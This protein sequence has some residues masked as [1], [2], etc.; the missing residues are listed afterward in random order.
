M[1]I[2]KEEYSKQQ[3]PYLNWFGLKC[4]LIIDHPD[5]IQMVMTS[6]SCIEK[7]NIYPNLFVENIGQHIGRGS[8]DIFH[9]S[10]ACAM[11]II[12][13]FESPKIFI[14]RLIKLRHEGLIT[15]EDVRDQV[16]FIMFAGQDTSS[17]TIAMTI[18]L[19]AMHP[20]IG[21]RVVDEI[22]EVLDYLPVDS[23][24]TME[25]VNKLTYLE[26][27]IKET[28]RLHPVVPILFRHCT[29]Y[30]SMTNFVIS[31]DTEVVIPAIR[32]HRRKDIWGEDAD[33]FN[34][35]HFPKEVSSKRSPFAFVAFSNG[36]RNCFGR[37][38]AFISIKTTLA[39]VLRS[40]KFSTHLG[41]DDLKFRLEITSKPVKKVLR[42]KLWNAYSHE[43]FS[44]SL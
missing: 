38:F 41:M 6:K 1:D 25:H 24:L 14:D 40:S 10:S 43:S 7:S 21:K 4:F 39:K 34:P 15:E 19:L 11:D 22:N 26:Q 16:N 8:F 29:E 5:D 2:L 17:F 31:K 44:D 36:P 13:D 3:T 30:T 32:A 42:S 20:S 37:R 27:V 33:E 28:L 9:Y 35:D 18:L 12:C 23:D